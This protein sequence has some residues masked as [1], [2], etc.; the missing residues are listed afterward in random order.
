VWY[1]CMYVCMF[2]GMYVCACG[3]LKLT[4]SPFTI[5]PVLLKQGL[6]LNLELAALFNLVS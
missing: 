1:A 2:T 3:V 6:L 4:L 5:L